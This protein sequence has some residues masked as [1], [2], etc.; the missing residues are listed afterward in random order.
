MAGKVMIVDDDPDVRKTLSFVLDG[1]CEAVIEAGGGEEALG[2]F[3]GVNPALVLLDVSMPG[4]GGLEVLSTL[5]ALKPSLPII[6]LTSAD[7]VVTAKMALDLGA[8]MYMTKP[9]DVETLKK[10]VAR[11]LNHDPPPD[12]MPWKVSG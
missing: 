2:I 9:Y 4:M 1:C 7:D 8:V 10:E 12:P 3:A 11:I 5:H 6:M